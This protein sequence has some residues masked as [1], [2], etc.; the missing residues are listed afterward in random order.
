MQNRPGQ[1]SE[2]REDAQLSGERIGGAL[3]E[4][5]VGTGV[6]ANNLPL[7]QRESALKVHCWV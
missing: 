7:E 2:A 3:L 4:A 5:Q 1:Q 6:D